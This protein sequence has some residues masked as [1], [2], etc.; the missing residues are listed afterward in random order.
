LTIDL[1]LDKYKAKSA[2]VVGLFKAKAKDHGTIIYRYYFLQKNN[3][4][5]NDRTHMTKCLFNSVVSIVIV[6]LDFS[7]EC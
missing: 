3:S 1:M 5:A 6:M 2:N 4:L 7:K